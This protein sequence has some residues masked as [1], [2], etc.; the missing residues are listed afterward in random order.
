ML[1]F[2][3]TPEAGRGHGFAAQQRLIDRFLTEVIG[4]PA[5]LFGNSLGGLLAIMQA[6]K[7]PHTVAKLVLVSPAQPPG[8]LHLPSAQLLTRAML[9]GVPD[10]GEL[11]L[12]LDARRGGPRKMFL[13]LLSLGCSDVTRVPPEVIDANVDALAERFRELPWTHQQSFLAT[14]R[15]LAPA[16]VR[17]D[18]FRAWVDAISAPTLL[19]H[20]SEDKLVPIQWSEALSRRRRDWSFVRLDDLGHVPQMEDAGRFVSAVEAWLESPRGATVSRAS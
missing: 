1:G 17:I 5:I 10:I 11:A 8:S 19:L 2:G 3:R 7:S 20:G 9:H 4:E 14:S 6:A 18:R 13:D 16:L 12:Q 15:A